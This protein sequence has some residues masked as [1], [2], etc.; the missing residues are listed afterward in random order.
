[1]STIRTFMSATGAIFISLQ[2]LS[3]RRLCI[4]GATPERRPS[5]PQSQRRAPQSAARKMSGLS[6]SRVGS[7]STA[8]DKAATLRS[9]AT[10]GVVVHQPSGASA[11]AKACAVRQIKTRPAGNQLTKRGALSGRSSSFCDDKFDVSMMC[12]ACAG[13][14]RRRREACGDE[15]SGGAGGRFVAWRMSLCSV[16]PRAGDVLET[17]A[18]PHIRGFASVPEKSHQNEAQPK[19]VSRKYQQKRRSRHGTRGGAVKRDRRAKSLQ[20]PR[21]RLQRRARAAPMRVSFRACEWAWMRIHE[22]RS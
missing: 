18:R 16:L 3:I 13:F 4:L 12:R 14:E 6:R 1:M 11:S 22:S 10:R 2:N 5:A 9:A 21:S 17:C 7:D 8:A 20:R 19:N 15:K